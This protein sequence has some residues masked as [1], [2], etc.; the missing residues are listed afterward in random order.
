MASVRHAPFTTL[1]L[2]TLAAAIVTASLL[3]EPVGAFAAWAAAA[4]IVAAV[5]L[6]RR[7]RASRGSR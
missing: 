4:V 3:S 2:V 7:R 1:E 6:W 5:L